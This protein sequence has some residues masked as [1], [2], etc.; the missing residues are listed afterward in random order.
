MFM[1]KILI[2]ALVTT[3]FIGGFFIYKNFFNPG[4][5]NEEELKNK[6]ETTER[7]SD[8]LINYLASR[9]CGNAMCEIGENSTNCIRDCQTAQISADRWTQVNGP[10][11][12]LIQGVGCDTMSHDR[13]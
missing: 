9:T 7:P 10:Y 6:E 5:K 8:P 4:V 2:I 12:G 3:I 1:K 11:G 13:M